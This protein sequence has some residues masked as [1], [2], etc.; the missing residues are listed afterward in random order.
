MVGKGEGGQLERLTPNRFTSALVNLFI[1]D[2]GSFQILP[3]SGT[4]IAKVPNT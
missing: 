2:E 1:P 3:A 4:G